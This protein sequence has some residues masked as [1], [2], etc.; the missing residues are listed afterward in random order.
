M[1]LYTKQGD[2]GS[3]CLYGG[4]RVGKDHPRVCA[5]GEVDELNSALGL[6]CAALRQGEILE[7]LRRVQSDL[8][9]IGGELANPRG[10]GSVV[11]I[12]ESDIRRLE[13][14]IDAC[15]DAVEPLRN[16]ILPGGGE[17]AARLH[18]SRSVCR[19]AE[20]AVVLLAHT[21]PVR[22]DVLVYLNRLGDLLFALAR[23]LNHDAG[24]ADI[25][26]RAPQ[27]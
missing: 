18:L 10:Q 3:T 7:G 5:Y 15:S 8:F 6:S 23:M 19:R 1:K 21:E 12:G 11:A 16:F 27:P 17:P 13:Q 9:V 20:R 26:W 4:A 22:G 24:I 2:D 14:W 25:P